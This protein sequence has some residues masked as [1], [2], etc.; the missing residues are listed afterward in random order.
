MIFKSAK[1]CRERWLNH[2]DNKK[3]HGLWSPLEDYKIFK[4]VIENGKRWCKMVSILDDKRT[5]HMIKN[6][7]NS[8]INKKRSNKKQKE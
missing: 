8:L 5:E 7:Y 4:F 3:V 6:R 2:L 1:H